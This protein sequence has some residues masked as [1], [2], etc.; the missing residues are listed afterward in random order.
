MKIQK[1]SITKKEFLMKKLS[2][3]MKKS[4]KCKEYQRLKKKKK[5]CLS[6]RKTCMKNKYNKQNIN[7]MINLKNY[8]NNKI[9]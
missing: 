2:V 3:L 5:K 9:K 4:L 8:K 7:I 6:L 1:T